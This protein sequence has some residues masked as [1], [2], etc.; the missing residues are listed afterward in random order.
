MAK[1]LYSALG[2]EKSAS[3]DEIKRAYRK[4]AAKYHP[5]VN[6][7]KGADEKFK[8]IQQAW[9]VLSDPQK[10]AQYD[11]FGSTGDPGG[12]FNGGQGGFGGFGGAQYGDFAGGFEGG[13]G[14]IFET[15]FGGGRGS[16]QKRGPSRGRNLQGETTISLE[17]AFAGKKHS[18][19]VDTYASCSTCT[20][21]GRKAGTG[22][23]SC[24]NCSGT[25]QVARQQRTPFGV[26]QTA[27]T[28]PDCK[29]E[30]RV[31]E[32]PCKDCH[33]E[34]RIQQNQ[35]ITVEIPPGVFDGALLRVPGKGEAGEKG[36]PA[37]DFLLR[38]H[39]ANHKSF[40]R[41]ENDIH[42]EEK[43]SMLEAVLGNTKK[44]KTL[45]GEVSVQIPAGTQPDAV[46]R[47][48]GKGMPIL[49]RNG[50]GDHMIHLRVEIPKKLSKKEKE[51]FSELANTSGE[52]IT[53]QKG[54]FDGL[55]S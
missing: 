18:I 1:D 51:L 20:G 6:K 30:G 49:N 35:T 3:A 34:G 37:G 12:G 54:I 8:E 7:E 14:D 44:I 42:S 45:H 38:V 40:Q 27:S 39:V 41:D 29:G 53:P 28:C 50:Y 52:D 55:F 25:G 48:R 24:S 2:I 10:K 16:A 21:S 4:L 19:E 47:I 13:L 36:Q 11:R 26:I 31:P 17:D 43:I 23:K 9:E 32:Q 22:M 46:L 5:D 15:F 33:G